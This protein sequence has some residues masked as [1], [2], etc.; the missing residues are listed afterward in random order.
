MGTRAD[1][2]VGTGPN[3]EWIGSISYDGDP[4]GMPEGAVKSKSEKKYRAEVERLLADREVLSTRP[5]EG[6]PWP[7]EDS[8]TT[9]YAYAWADG[10]V[11]I[12]AFGR[13]WQSIAEHNRWSR[14]E[15]E[16]P[17]MA[18][19]EVRD[20]SKHKMDNAGVMAKSGLLIVRA[21]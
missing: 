1:F 7:W 5:A 10:K 16:R 11:K 9:D 20:M 15:L 19:S 12:S 6:W 18:D 4:D 14:S 21:R 17:Q 3:A 2:Y 13:G 8:R